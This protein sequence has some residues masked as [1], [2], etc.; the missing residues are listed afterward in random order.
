MIHINVNC[1]PYHLLSILAVVGEYPLRQLHLL[2]NP[3]MYR[4]T[5]RRMCQEQ[6]YI[7]DETKEK[8][9]TKALTITGKGFQRSVRLL[10]GAEPLLKWVGANKYY[11][12]AYG[13]YNFSGGEKHRLRNFRIAETIALCKMAGYEYRPYGL[14]DLRSAKNYYERWS[15]LDKI[16]NRL[17]SYPCMYPVRLLKGEKD[18]EQKKTVFTRITGAIFFDEQVYPL[19]NLGDEIQ[20]LWENSEIKMKYHLTELNHANGGRC[21][22]HSC[23]FLTNDGMVAVKSLR[24]IYNKRTNKKKDYSGTKFY[25]SVYWVPLTEDGARQLRFFCVP[26]WWHKIEQG[27]FA[28]AERAWTVSYAYCIDGEVQH[29]FLC[30]DIA[31]LICFKKTVLKTEIPFAIYCFPHQVSFLEIF[32]GN[33]VSLRIVKLK[34]IENLLKADEYFDD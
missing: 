26:L 3:R 33:K 10:Q 11:G 15:A 32:F 34:Q 7:N 6:E 18:G 17:P 8:I 30:G 23:I 12:E 16:P 2:G 21:D 31:K 28:R 14:P 29:S 1:Q 13:Q 22:A 9:T 20:K 19:Y 5:I 4:D 27:L 24:Y 25:S